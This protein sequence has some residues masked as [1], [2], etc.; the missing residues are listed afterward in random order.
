M[1]C[2]VPTC[3]HNHYLGYDVIIYDVLCYKHCIAHSLSDGQWK[4]HIHKP[5][6]YFLECMEFIDCY[7][8]GKNNIVAQLKLTITLFILTV[9]SK[10]LQSIDIHQFP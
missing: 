5:V 2:A 9:K 6:I 4:F 3:Y 7:S 1:N 8:S 10:S